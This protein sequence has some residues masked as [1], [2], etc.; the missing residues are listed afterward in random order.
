MTYP[1]FYCNNNGTCQKSNEQEHMRQQSFML[2]F[3]NMLID[4]K[5]KEWEGKDRCRMFEGDEQLFADPPMREEC[6]ICCL[7]FQIDGS[8]KFYQACCGKSIC[9]GCIHHVNIST[10]ECPCPYCRTPACDNTQ[11]RE[12][13]ARLNKRAD[14]GDGEA[15]RTLGNHYNG[16]WHGLEKDMKKAIE[17]WNKGAGLGSMISHYYLG[18]AYLEGHDVKEDVE[19]AKHHHGIAAIG[20]NIGA[21]HRLGQME[22][23]EMSKTAYR[24]AG[25]VNGVNLARAAKHYSIAAKAGCEKSMS[26]ITTGYTNDTFRKYITKNEYEM[27]LRAHKDATDA[28]KS[29][30]RD[31]AAKWNIL[32]EIARK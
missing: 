30:Q 8:Q 19:K 1:I 23:E 24:E 17:F 31:E 5:K 27:I 9:H 6:P 16:G 4:A 12:M 28:M 10:D 2:S 29:D 20:G 26:M 32:Q 7:P 3:T 14:G 22:I 13:F 18:V 25:F 15:L 21:R 11:K